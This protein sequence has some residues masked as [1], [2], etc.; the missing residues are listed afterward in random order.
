ML[1]QIVCRALIQNT[2]TVF[3]KTKHIKRHR[4]A[5]LNDFSCPRNRLYFPSD[6]PLN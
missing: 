4:L 6:D 2:G 5:L 1:L 3:P